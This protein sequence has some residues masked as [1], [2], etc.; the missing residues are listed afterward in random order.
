MKFKNIFLN[1][2]KIFLNEI[3]KNLMVGPPGLNLGP[4]HYEAELNL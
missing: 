1:E 2:K 3:V 4:I